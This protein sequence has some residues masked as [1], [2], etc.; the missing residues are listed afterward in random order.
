MSELPL[1][2]DKRDTFVRHLDR[3]RVPQLTVV[4]TSAQASLCRPAGYANPAWRDAANRQ[5]SRRKDR[6]NPRASAGSIDQRCEGATAQ[7][8]ATVSAERGAL[9]TLRHQ[10]WPCFKGQR[11][12]ARPSDGGV[13]P[14]ELCRPHQEEDV[15]AQRSGYAD[16]VI[17]KFVSGKAAPG[18]I[19]ITGR[20]A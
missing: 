5:F 17:A 20:S 16:L 2:H 18:H 7:P 1:D 6:H 8:A 12:S 15:T 4:P 10:A 11:R 9:S 14:H 19:G 13:H 3:V